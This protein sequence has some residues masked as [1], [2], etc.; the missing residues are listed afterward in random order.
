MN[1]LTK[2]FVSTI[3]VL[4]CL[5]WSSKAIAVT[6]SWT[7]GGGYSATGNFTYNDANSDNF[8]RTGEFTSFNITF[9]DSGN[10]VLKTYDINQLQLFTSAFN[11]NYDIINNHI[12][13]TGNYN[14]ANGFSI[15]DSQNDGL[16]GGY[17]LYT[18]F[19]GLNDI[20]FDNGSSGPLDSG[21]TFNTQ[22]VPFEFSPTL[23]FLILGG[24]FGGRKLISAFKQ[25]SRG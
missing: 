4:G 10:A 7:G 11:F 5:Q 17:W 19:T 16:G 23:G 14:T 8:A 25:N 21:G 6:F 13:A 9:T 18:D 15:G 22:A 2:F 20:A 24:W 1:Q 12:L 3:A